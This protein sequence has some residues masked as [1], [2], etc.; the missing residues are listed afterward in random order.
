LTFDA[1]EKS[2]ESGNPAEL[3]EFRL[4]VEVFRYT[5]Y[6]IAVNRFAFDFEPVSIIRSRLTHQTNSREGDLDV[7]V[8]ADNDF[9]ELYS[10]TAV[11]G[12]KATLTFFR[13]HVDDPDEETVVFFRGN[14]TNV[15]KKKNSREA[16]LHVIS[17]LKAQSRTMPR[18]TFGGICQHHLYDENCRILE[19]NPSFEKFLNVSA[20]S[21]DGL[22]LTAD[23]AGAFGADFFQA[24]F[25]EWLA[26][27]RMIVAQG[28]AGNN[29]L[30]IRV[31]YTR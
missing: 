18:Q 3:Y 4:G 27:H 23:G 17:I 9:V 7:I 15:S 11:P 21:A 14:V 1:F 10:S 25:T 6:A 31:N 16:N 8:P 19:T 13:T 28:G 2:Q 20:V 22:T 5:S 29:D 30:T 26:D 24:G 12:G